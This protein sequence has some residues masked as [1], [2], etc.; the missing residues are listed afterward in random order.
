MNSLSVKYF[1]IFETLSLQILKIGFV[2]FNSFSL[3]PKM[4]IS[5]LGLCCAIDRPLKE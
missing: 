5:P 4:E 2:E 3:S 1:K